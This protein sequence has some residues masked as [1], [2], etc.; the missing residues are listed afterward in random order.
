MSPRYCDTADHGVPNRGF[1]PRHT[2]S[3]QKLRERAGALDA[4]TVPKAY[5]AAAIDIAAASTEAEAKPFKKSFREML[6]GSLGRA[7]GT[8]RTIPGRF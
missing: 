4:K 7:K 1:L 2:R 3:A 5:V 8:I 6:S